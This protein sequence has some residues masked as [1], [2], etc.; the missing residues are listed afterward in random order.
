MKEI[1]RS[2]NV[3]PEGEVRGSTRNEERHKN[4]VQDVAAMLERAELPLTPACCIYKV[5]PLLRE[6]NKEAYTPNVVSIGPFHSGDKRLQNMER[7]KLR[8]LKRFLARSNQV[9]LE[10]WIRVIEEME[11]NIRL[12]YAET[13]KLTRDEF[14]KV[15]LVDGGFILE[16][17][18]TDYFSDKTREDKIFLKPWLKNMIELDLLLLENQLPFFVLDKLFNVAFASRSSYPTSF[19]DLAFEFYSG[20]CFT[21]TKNQQLSPSPDMNI[22]HFTDLIR[23][24]QLPPPK[25]QQSRSDFAPPRQLPSITELKE[26]GVN[27]EPSS[28]ECLLDL[29]FSGKVLK[30]PSFVVDD[31]TETVFRNVMALEQC[32]Y[33]CDSY[34]TDYIVLLDF[35]IST[36]KDVDILVK[37]DI[38]TNY[39]GD[40]NRVAD[41]FNNLWKNV[42]HSNFNQEYLELCEKLGE[43]YKN[44]WHKR[45]ATLKRDYF[46]TP[47]MT[48][49]SIAGIVFL[50]L[51]FI[52]AVCSVISVV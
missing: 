21:H 6:L 22:K 12:C 9:S 46:G 10:N 42:T 24:F 13:I 47:W 34:I 5:P 23:Y 18:W 1:I 45:K 38:I 14:V 49:A 25:R 2:G 36:A 17:F 15:I 26:A 37:E 3:E 16:L 20:E 33:P 52:Q 51:S 28:E 32:H 50:I 19:L 27:F 31:R 30:I 40:S 35:L 8:Y 41:L 7:H 44:P 11:P 29:K 39:L 4:L 48:A 43:F